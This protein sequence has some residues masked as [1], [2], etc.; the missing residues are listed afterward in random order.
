MNKYRGFT[1][2][3][4]LVVIVVVGIL[5]TLVIVGYTTIQ[6]NAVNT[7]AQA[8]LRSSGQ[9]IETWTI[10]NGQPPAASQAGL[11]NLIAFNK[12][13]F[14]ENQASGSVSYCRNNTDFSLYGRTTQ[15]HVYIY[16]SQRGL[17]EDSHSGNLNEQ[18]A[19]GGV[20]SSAPGYERIWLLKGTANPDG[21][22]WQPWVRGTN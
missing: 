3:E 14:I 12:D 22:G 18:C 16:S 6:G 4:L 13:N 5:S 2:V 21:A 15:K 19:K 20:S 9:E 7:G 10:Q 1:I 8:D 17:F 11:E